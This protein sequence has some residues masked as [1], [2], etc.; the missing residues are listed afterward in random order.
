MTHRHQISCT[1]LL[2]MRECKIA[3]YMDRAVMKELYSNPKCA[4]LFVRYL[5]QLL[6]RNERRPALYFYE[7]NKVHILKLSDVT[8]SDLP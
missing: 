1:T 3:I 5:R 8:I 6:N 7:I 4:V 2:E